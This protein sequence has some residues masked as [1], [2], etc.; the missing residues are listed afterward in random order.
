MCSAPLTRQEGPREIFSRLMA[1]VLDYD[2]DAQADLY[3]EDGILEWP[4]APPGMPR[5]VEGREAIR[6]LLVPLG[7]RAR[8]SG[9][10]LRDY[11]HVMIHETTDP[12]V[13]IVEFDVTGESDNGGP[14]RLSYIQV[15][16]VRE[17]K[18]VSFRDYWNPQAL[19]S[20]LERA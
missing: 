13:I 2:M 19:V 20:L 6:E 10:R 15:L 1:A 3:A 9:R 7:E 5:R 8:Q 4:F 18:I 11:D 17:G 16:R 12:E 14:Y